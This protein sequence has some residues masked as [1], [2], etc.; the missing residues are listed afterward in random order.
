M[1]QLGYHEV[2]TRSSPTTPWF[3]VPAITKKLTIANEAFSLALGNY[4]RCNVKYE[5]CSAHD[6]SKRSTSD[7]SQTC[8]RCA[9]PYRYARHNI[10][11]AAFRSVCSSYG[12]S[13]SENFYGTF[14]VTNA[15]K[16]PDVIVYRG[17]TSEQ[18]LVLDFA[19]P[20]QSENEAY[21]SINIMWNAKKKKYQ[22]WLDDQVTVSPFIIGTNAVPHASTL[23]VMQEIEKQAIRKGFLRDCMARMK[24]AIVN[25]EVYRKKAIAARKM[26]NTLDFINE[27]SHRD[28]DD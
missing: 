13:T 22:E 27:P 10:T 16:R 11:I 4:L 19:I 26:A 7:H 28:D 18:P 14:G 25:F 1:E 23:T 8:H 20:H 17:A 5:V 15:Q 9:A 24:L 21:D 2:K 6:A 12:I 3:N